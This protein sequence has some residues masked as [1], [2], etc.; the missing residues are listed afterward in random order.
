MSSKLKPLEDRLVVK[1]VE[2]EERTAGGIVLPSSA[3]EK[4][5]LGEVLAVGPGRTL[6]N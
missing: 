4:P 5:Q 6:D 1:R 3:Q 2:A